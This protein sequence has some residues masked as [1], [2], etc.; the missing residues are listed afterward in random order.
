MSDP[1]DIRTLPEKV[2]SFVR[3]SFTLPTGEPQTQP[4]ENPLWSKLAQLGT[5]LW[6]DTGSV[7]D[8]ARLWTSDFSALTTNNTLLNREVQKGT[9]D[10]LI[11][12][13]AE[14]LGPYRLSKQQLKLEIAFI[15]NAVHGLGLVQQFNAMVSVELH[16]DLAGDVPATIEYARRYH[17]VCP[18]KFLV[19]IPLTPAGLLAGRKVAREGI[20]I[21]QTLGFSARQNY[22]SARLA[23]PDY[24]NV[25][26]GRLNSFVADNHLGD[27]LF[28][29]EDATLAS[30]RGIRQLRANQGIPT[31][32]I[33]ASFR[34][35]DQIANLA[36]ID[37]MTIPPKVAQ[38]FLSCRIE[39]SSLT[40]KT[41]SDYK[42]QFADGVD[43]TAIGFHTLWDIN[44]H[45]PA[46]MDV[47]EKENLDAFTPD[48]LIDFFDE[49]GCEDILLRWSAHQIATSAAEG[50]I[51]K[52]ENW[53]DTLAC[54]SIGL[55]SLMNLAGMGSF[56][57]DQAQ[58]DARV[59]NQLNEMH[60]RAG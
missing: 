19:K 49:Y 22:I 42:P 28:V 30:Q 59:E 29:G 33:G 32:Q 25:F 51:P 6:L 55:D 24:V 12:D 4:G 58:M 38:E 17:Q 35:G 14:L 40:D 11:R 20:R 34:N 27:G 41:A 56:A 13:A 36:G 7:E 54:G 43:V 1:E 50:K 31:R 60:L 2:R 3:R 57:A 45:I 10:S 46:C 26:L 23:R 8:A 47:L 21:N 37:V 15:L 53:A 5:E 52:L 18:E 48:D 39:P 44:P 9:Y 16:T